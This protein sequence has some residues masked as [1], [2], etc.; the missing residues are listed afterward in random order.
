M[1]R[2]EEFPFYQ[3]HGNEI[4]YLDNAATSM[5][6]KYARYAQTD[7][8]VTNRANPFRGSYPLS[9][10]ATDIYER[11]R[12]RVAEFINAEPD[13]IIFTRNATESLNLAAWIVKKTYPLGAALVSESCHHSALFP[14]IWPQGKARFVRPNKEGKISDNA[15][16]DALRQNNDIVAVVLDHASNV[17]G[18]VN[19]IKS[20]TK[21][22]HNNCAIVVVDGAQS[23]PHLKIDVK[24][25]DVDMFAFSGHK[26]CAPTGIGALYC[27]K[28]LV[29]MSYPLYTGGGMVSD[30]HSLTDIEWERPPYRF[31]AGT[32]NSSGAAALAGAC[33]FYNKVGYEYIMNRERELTDRLV[34]GMLKIPGVHIFGSPYPGNHLSLV[35]FTVD[36]H[37]PDEVGRIL[38]NKDICIR[39]GYHCARP[40]HLYMNEGKQSCR[41]SLMFYNTEEEIDF[42]L[43]ELRKI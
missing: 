13:E 30:Y 38:G 12:S 29:D 4:C 17:F 10:R 16:Y 20:L 5:T 6:C 14:W 25:L 3:V 32:P 39:T 28:Y 9:G 31:E 21:Q 18:S 22:A 23:I 42:F 8:D 40:L 41:V 27:K 2:R 35:S 1:N 7:A 43:D 19:N 37:E 24:D 36:G 11:S 34:K 15:L 26:M 33:D